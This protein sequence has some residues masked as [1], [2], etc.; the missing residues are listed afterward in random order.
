MTNIVSGRASL[1]REAVR[2][3]W[4]FAKAE[5]KWIVVFAALIAIEQRLLSVTYN[6][7][8]M[9]NQIKEAQGNSD[10]ILKI[11]N[12][13]TPGIVFSVITNITTTM[14]STYIFTTRYLRRFAEGSVPDFGAKS[15]F[16]WLSKIIQKYLILIFPLFLLMAIFGAVSA[17]SSGESAQ[18][19]L[20]IIFAGLSILWMFYFFCGIYLLYL[21]SPLALL[22]GKEPVLK[23][24]A[25]MTKNELLRVWWGSMMAIGVIF[26]V[27]FP[28]ILI[29]AGISGAMGMDVAQQRAFGLL[30]DGAMESVVNAAVAVYTCVAYRV[31]S[32]EQAEK[33]APV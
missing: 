10:E 5:W 27:F 18:G 22:R 24:S 12:S 29:D 16:V 32:K 2:D 25:R 26:I 23:I 7:K 19:T 31:L 17:K 21:V 20:S 9:M 28:L 14:V 6:L 8:D 11:I 1:W 15:F 30:I 33:A 13:F 4:A 3:L